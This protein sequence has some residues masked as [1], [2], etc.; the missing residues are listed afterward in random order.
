MNTK[1]FY[2]GDIQDQLIMPDRGSNGIDV[3]LDH[4]LTNSEARVNDDVKKVLACVIRQAIVRPFHDYYYR[5]DFGPGVSPQYHIVSHDLFCTCALEADCAAV[6]AVRMYLRDGGEPAK[7]P[8]PGY[9]LTV[10]H[11]CPICGSRAYYQPKLSSNNRGVGW[12]CQTGEKKHY[13]QNEL[14]AL[15]AAY[16]AKWKK[17]AIDPSSFQKLSTFSFKDGYDPEQD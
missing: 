12:E 7:T 6:I 14:A 15:Q 2:K 4:R 3:C 8:R 1:A 13:W 17:L 11:V 16:A 5:V 9:F 10:P